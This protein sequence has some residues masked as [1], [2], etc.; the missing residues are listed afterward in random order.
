CDLRRVARL[1]DGEDRGHRGRGRLP[2]TEGREPEGVET[3]EDEDGDE[4]R[5]DQY[6]HAAMLPTAWPRVSCADASSG[7][8]R[9]RRA[10]D[11][12]G[13]TGAGP[14]RAER[15]ELHRHRHG[16]AAGG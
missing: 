16:G 14:A 15:H 13:P 10:A 6:T 3:A 12:R 2:W 5:R 9:A 11:G 8:T 1:D 4:Q 7:R